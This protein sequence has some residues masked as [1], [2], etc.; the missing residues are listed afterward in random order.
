MN[1]SLNQNTMFKNMN[2]FS[3]AKSISYDHAVTVRL[4]QSLRDRT[5]DLQAQCSVSV[6]A[7]IYNSSVHSIM[8]PHKTVS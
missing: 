5:F 7:K 3:A 4:Q 8:L 1:A 2:K 6:L